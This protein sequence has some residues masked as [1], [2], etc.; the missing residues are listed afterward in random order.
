MTRNLSQIRLTRG[1]KKVMYAAQVIYLAYFRNINPVKNAN[2]LVGTCYT[3][4]R[5]ETGLII[6]IFL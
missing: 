2:G 5:G 6:I 1:T 4:P 3:K